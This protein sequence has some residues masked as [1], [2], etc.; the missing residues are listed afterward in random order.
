MFLFHSMNGQNI[1]IC[2]FKMHHHLSD[3]SHK[4]FGNVS[5][6]IENYRHDFLNQTVI[7]K[8]RGKTKDVYNGVQTQHGCCDCPSSAITF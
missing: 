3:I 7:I 8:T 4:N 2:A 1:I 5:S 6:V